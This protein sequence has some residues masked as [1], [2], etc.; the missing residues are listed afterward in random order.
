MPPDL[1]ESLPHT[2]HGSRSSEPA[3]R[4]FP[5][6]FRPGLP[7]RLTL[8]AGLFA[9]EL[10]AISIWLD[11][12]SLVG[13][14][15]LT[16]VMGSWGPAALRAIVAFASIYVILA[17]RTDKTAFRKISG[18]LAHER[19][20]WGLLA[21]H[22]G[23]LLVFAGV[24]PL[25]FDSRLAA[26]WP[27]LMAALWLAAGLAAIPLGTFAFIPPR[28]CLEFLARNRRA[29]VYAA[30]ATAGACLVRTDFQLL[31][32]LIAGL[33]FGM[34]KLLLRPFLA[35]VIADPV[36]RELGTS[37]F[38]VEISKE[39]SG[40]E[41]MGLMLVFGTTW[42]WFFRREC[43]FPQAL[44]LIPAGVLTVWMLNA[45]R[46]AALILIGN[47]GAPDI[48][49]GGFHSQAGW[50]A[51]IAVSLC[52]CLALRRVP[53][54][55]KR[56]AVPTT[57][58]AAT[59]NPT[60]A[61]LMPLLAIL[62]AAMAARAASSNF[63]WLYPLRLF[64]ASVT[65]WKFRRKYA[66]LDWRFGWMAPAAGVVVLAMWL[67]LDRAA[68]GGSSDSGMAS[69]LADLPAPGR[70]AW[71][72]CRTLAAV[73]TVPIAEELAFRG[74]LIRRLISADF[75]SLDMRRFTYPA[76][77]ISSVAF[78][79][80]HGGR[81]VAGT[82]AGLIYAFVLLRRGRIGDAVFAHGTTNALLAIWVLVTGRWDFW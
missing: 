50:M 42:L 64:A 65:L 30:A 13:K 35:H 69:G 76:V 25:L 72:A 62:A 39:C 46:I 37:S 43:R 55:T 26:S 68:G 63:E 77:L 14:G 31:W 9:L 4:R 23:A 82:V 38:H 34:V 66:E 54:L 61:Y 8:L 60:A 51:F 52:F 56:A 6:L 3:L 80:M 10:I 16:G 29:L 5:D 70:A 12:A 47:A 81:W 1:A 58:T 22:A 78:G 20:G 40:L 74:F 49:T 45:V 19:M 41:G 71:L 67:A 21:G 17:W 53:W 57:R 28:L 32:N 15:G 18:Q 79:L 44:L 2:S 73:I 59:E 48:A 36:L 27:N 24:S 11:A 7:Q 75:E 33:T